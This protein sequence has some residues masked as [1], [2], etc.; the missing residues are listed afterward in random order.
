MKDEE[1][2]AD[3][4]RAAECSHNSHTK[5]LSYRKNDAYIPN[6]T[7]Y[8]MLDQFIA[9]K[10]CVKQAIVNDPIELVENCIIKERET[11][12]SNKP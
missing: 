10:T 12:I 6:Q 9:T 8:L 11:G 3:T 2:H 5:P 4:A 1:S 7:S